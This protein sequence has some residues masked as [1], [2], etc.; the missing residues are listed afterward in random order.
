[1]RDWTYDHGLLVPHVY[2]QMATGNIALYSRNGPEAYEALGKIWSAYQR[3]LLRLMAPVAGVMLELRARLAVSAALQDPSNREK[4]LRRAS[5]D[6][7]K[8]SKLSLTTCGPTAAFLAAQVAQARGDLALA[9]HLLTRAEQLMSAAG[10]AAYAAVTQACR[11]EL[12]QGDEGAA[13]RRSALAFFQSK[14]IAQPDRMI[15]ML[16]PA[17]A[18]G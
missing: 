5:K 12:L 1:M 7:R 11:G 17:F 2:M 15:G 13:L 3:S 8:L 6:I 16:A 10:F 9:L 14:N 18:R 4:L